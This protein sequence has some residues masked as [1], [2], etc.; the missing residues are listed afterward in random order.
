[1]PLPVAME[2][3]QWQAYYSTCPSPELQRRMHRALVSLV[4]VRD[5]KHTRLGILVQYSAG[6][7][8][9]KT[10]RVPVGET[11]L[12]HPVAPLEAPS[13]VPVT[14]T[15]LAAS[16]DTTLITGN[17]GSFPVDGQSTINSYGG[18]MCRTGQTDVNS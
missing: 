10:V 13:P 1:M 14:R 6:S 16:L 18:S 8:S 12:G 17:V 5:S 15:L 11:W 7:A 4:L 2:Y 3:S 9:V